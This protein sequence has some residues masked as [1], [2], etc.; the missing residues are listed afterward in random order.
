M[1]VM[2]K[3]WRQV[4]MLLSG[5][6][7]LTAAATAAFPEKERLQL[8]LSTELTKSNG[9]FAGPADVA[10]LYY[11]NA[12]AELEIR[13]YQLEARWRAV[14][15]LTLVAAARSADLEGRAAAGSFLNSRQ[16][17]KLRDIT[18]GAD[19]IRPCFWG[20]AGLMA[21]AIFNTDPDFEGG[22]TAIHPVSDGSNAYDLTA[23]V[24]APAFELEHQLEL[25]WRLFETSRWHGFLQDF[26]LG[27]QRHVRYEAS[28]RV[29]MFRFAGF[30]DTTF[31]E[32]TRGT[33]F[34]QRPE[35]SA[36]GLKVGCNIV[37]S[38]EVDIG[39]RDTYDGS[40]H[41]DLRQWTFGV[42]TRF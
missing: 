16:S 40:D 3:P 13:E 41:L 26:K 39:Y 31:S 8:R 38:L 20:K 2:K 19:V 37:H 42:Q 17:Q 34:Y 4:F 36:W 32:K 9:F 7:C 33:F 24:Q 12:G 35:A 10:T 11:Q 22:S 5:L 23:F 18:L 15:P 28:Q 27:Q 30:L 29:M 14:S 1:V 21:R 25:G 6:L